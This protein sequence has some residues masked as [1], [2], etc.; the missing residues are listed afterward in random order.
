MRIRFLAIA[1]GLSLLAPPAL[2]EADTDAF[3][4]EMKEMVGVAQ[5]DLSAASL[6]W[7]CDISTQYAC[8]QKGCEKIKPSVWIIVNFLES[9][10]QRCDQKGCS[11]APFNY[12]RAGAYSTFGANGTFLK[13]RN[14][15]KEFAEAASSHT[16][17]FNGFGN[18]KP[19]K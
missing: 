17:I 7:R 8:G 9:K 11:D 18:C 6:H 13:I 14:D 19:I 12:L 16:A 5:A 10:Y 3:L 1:L 2:S 15:G 4:K